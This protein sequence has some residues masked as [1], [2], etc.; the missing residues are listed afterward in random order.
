MNLIDWGVLIDIYALGLNGDIMEIYERSMQVLRASFCS[1][2]KMRPKERLILFNRI[3]I[4]DVMDLY[5][6]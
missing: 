5:S 1:S 4:L 3:S 2:C 6:L